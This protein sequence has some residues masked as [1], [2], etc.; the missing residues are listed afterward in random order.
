MLRKMLRRCKHITNERW[1]SWAAIWIYGL[2]FGA[3]T[4]PRLSTSV[5]GSSP[6]GDV[7]FLSVLFK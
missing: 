1:N 4:M 5:V 2:D 7:N 6:S 3:F